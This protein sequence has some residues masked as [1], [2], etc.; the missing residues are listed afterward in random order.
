MEGDLK[1]RSKCHAH[2]HHL[3]FHEL[4]LPPALL[5]NL[6]REKQWRT[7]SPM[8]SNS[9]GYPMGSN[10]SGLIYY[11]C[12]GEKEDG[13]GKAEGR[14]SL[15]MDKARSKMGNIISYPI[16]KYVPVVI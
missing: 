12:R 9:S 1:K 7:T 3:K 14:L 11:F 13:R 6:L 5:A 2:Q 8:G 10:S 4:A 15:G 16:R